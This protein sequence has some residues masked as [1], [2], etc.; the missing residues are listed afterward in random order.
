MPLGEKQSQVNHGVGLMDVS[1][2][3][4]LIGEQIT[5]EVFK[6]LVRAV[7]EWCRHCLVLISYWNLQLLVSANHSTKVQL[8]SQIMFCCLGIGPQL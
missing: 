7:P 3:T 2:P 5:L 8:K 6:T 4:V 1:D